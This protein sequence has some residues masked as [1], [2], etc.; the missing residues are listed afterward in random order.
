MC[1]GLR[2][3]EQEDEKGLAETMNMLRIIPQIVFDDICDAFEVKYGHGLLGVVWA[4]TGMD[5]FPD[6]REEPRILSA[7]RR[8]E[9]KRW[10]NNLEEVWY[11]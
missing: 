8:T 9:I 6:H 5:Q 3:L 7:R 2:E 1:I 4:V 11:G 10:I